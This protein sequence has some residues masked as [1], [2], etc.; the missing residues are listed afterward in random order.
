MKTVIVMLV[1]VF[2]ASVACAEWVTVAESTKGVV[3][4]IKAGSLFKMDNDKIAVVIGRVVGKD[5]ITPYLWSITKEDCGV[6]VGIVLWTPPDFIYQ[7]KLSFVFD[8][9]NVNSEIAQMICLAAGF[10]K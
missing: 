1:L 6:G 7:E 5:K 9:G 8:S 3:Y 2:T 4:D 10:I